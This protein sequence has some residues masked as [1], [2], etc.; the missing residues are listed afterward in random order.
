MLTASFARLA[1]LLAIVVLHV[2]AG[3]TATALSATGTGP[4]FAPDVRPA[5]L[6]LTRTERGMSTVIHWKGPNRYRSIQ[7]VDL[8]PVDDIYTSDV[9]GSTWLSGRGYPRGLRNVSVARNVAQVTPDGWTQL[10]ADL[11]M[12]AWPFIARVRSGGAPLTPVTVG[13]RTLL[14]GTQPLAANE[15]AGFAAGTRTIHLDPRTLVPVRIL[16]RRGRSID[17]NS[18][19]TTRRAQAS[20]FA[21]LTVIGRRELR[22]ERFTRQTLAQANATATWPIAMPTALPAGFTLATL[23]TAP[24]GSYLGP[25]G[26]FPRSRGVFFAK[27]TYGLES[28]D[29]T[30]RPARSTLTRDWDESDPFGGECATAATSEVMVGSITAKYAQGEYG[31]PRLW[32]RDG[33]TLYTLS[34]PFSAEQLATVARSLV[35]VTT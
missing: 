17:F 23:G 10:D 32:W 2:L 24:T 7:R 4:D 25:E 26:S 33:T 1:A 16:D 11:M 22:D 3:T 15:C 20:D 12:W 9:V 13:G 18:T 6:H 31:S 5:Q 30:I 27:W 21:A 35:T 19:I 34:G 8:D 14:R 29:L 28:I